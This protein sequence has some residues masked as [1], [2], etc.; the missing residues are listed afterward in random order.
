MGCYGVRA[1]GGTQRAHEI[2]VRMALGANRFDTLQLVLRRGVVLAAVGVAIGLLCA[3]IL[4]RLSAYVLYG[5]RAND[6]LI[7]IAASATLAAVAL[8]ACYIPARRATRMDPMLAL[9]YE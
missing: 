8:L 1:F 9:R 4:A 2:C 6:P 3:I 5:V 7:F